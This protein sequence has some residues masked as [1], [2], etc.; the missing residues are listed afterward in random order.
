[1]LDY[2]LVIIGGNLAGINAAIT[3]SQFEARVALV[4]LSNYHPEKIYQDKFDRT[5]YYI[6]TLAQIGVNV[7]NIR[8]SA[9][10]MLEENQKSLKFNDQLIGNAINTLLHN[11]EEQKSI[12]I[13]A[14]RGVDIVYGQ[15]Y[16]VNNP[17]LA[18]IVNNRQF[19]SRRYLITQGLQ[20]LIPPI[21]NLG[22]TGYITRNNLLEKFGNFASIPQKLVMIGAE[23]LGIELAQALCR[24]GKDI[25]I[26]VKSANI[27]H[28]EEPEAA[29]LVQCQLEAEGVKI[30]TETEVTQTQL[31]DQQKWV[32]AGQKAIETDEIFLATGYH[33][34]V[35]SLKLTDVGVQYN[36]NRLYLND[37]LQTTNPKIY[38][39]GEVAGGYPFPHIGIYESQ[40]AVKN[41]L[42]FPLFKVNYKGIPWAVFT[43]PQ[44]ARIGLT[45]AQARRRYKNDIVVRREDFKM[46]D[47]SLILDE[48]TGFCQIICRANGEILG[49]CIVGTQASELINNI[50]LAMRQGLKINSLAELPLPSPTLGEI[51]NQTALNWQWERFHQNKP[52]ENLLEKLCYWQRY[53]SS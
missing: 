51:T 47:R 41:A 50:A 35:D 44:M 21:N 33:L 34:H 37:Y 1:M 12:N 43:D 3:A 45:E 30:F 26:V 38:A 13:L 2:D 7:N 14:T 10:L 4:V 39:C 53:W 32:Q 24:L 48:T 29:F 9:E 15:G 11:W 52:W 23:P 40:I 6:K 22:N 42:F 8:Q 27:L 17:K 31:I 18:F 28:K 49:A 20:P 25:T 46:L 19:R 36:Q 16:F 5:Y